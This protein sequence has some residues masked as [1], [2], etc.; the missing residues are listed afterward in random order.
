MATSIFHQNFPGVE[1]L[2]EAVD[3]AAY[4]IGLDLHKK[5]VAICVVDQKEQEKPVFQ[6]KRLR[7]EEL[8]AKIQSFP[9]RK[10]VVCE[11]A[12]GWFPLREALEGVEDVVLV[13]LDPR[14]TSAWIQSSGVKNDKIDAEVLCHVCL[15][16]GIGRLCVHQPS[17]EAKER[18]KLVQYRDRLVRERTRIKNQLKNM[19]KDYGVNP[20]TGEIFLKSDLMQY[21]EEDLLGALERVG[22]RIEHAEKRIDLLSADDEVVKRLISIPGVGPMTAFALRWKIEDISRFKDSAHLCSYFGFG[23]RQKQSGESC[24]RG[25]ITKKGNT[26]VRTLL[27]QGAQVVR[28]RRKDL[29]ELY[30]PRLGREELMQVRRH[31]NKVVTALARKQLV[32]AFHLWRK[33]EEFD[34]NFYQQRREQSSRGLERGTTPVS[35]SKE[36]ELVAYAVH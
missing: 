7:N 18:F 5:T 31:A 27:I 15:Q 33:G 26:M 36:A 12:Y 35:T 32:F 34:L 4:I 24:M 21:L 11:A 30:F 14:K 13:L 22:A 6:R 16:G 3:G 25:K 20:Y 8:I 23:I 29:V 9:G 28:N 1:K 17:R 10:V 19:E 2:Q